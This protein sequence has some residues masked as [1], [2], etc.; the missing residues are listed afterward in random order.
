[1][2]QCEAI[3]AES[4]ADLHEKTFFPAVAEQFGEVFYGHRMGLRNADNDLKLSDVSSEVH[5]ISQVLTGAVYDIMADIFDNY[6]NFKCHDPAETLYKA[7]KHM[8]SL[9]LVSILQLPDKNATYKDL[10]EKMTALE[11]KEEW[12]PIIQKQFAVREIIGVKAVPPVTRPIAL[13]F[14]QC[15]GTLRYPE[16]IERIQQAAKTALV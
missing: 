2:D 3:I 5:E 15:S 7:G 1:M 9:L 10:A 13:S 4:K 11:P 16:N 8:I 14:K 12:K 6:K